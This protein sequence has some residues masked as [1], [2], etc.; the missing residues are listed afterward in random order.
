MT[1]EEKLKEVMKIVK[2]AGRESEHLT[3][4]LSYEQLRAI[5]AVLR[6]LV[7]IKIVIGEIA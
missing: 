4:D 1:N 7:E 3:N 5:H 2:E 6:A